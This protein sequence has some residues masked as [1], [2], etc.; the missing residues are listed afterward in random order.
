[1]LDLF[2]CFCLYFILGL[3]FFLFCWGLVSERL[4]RRCGWH[5]CIGAYALLFCGMDGPGWLVTQT[6]TWLRYCRIAMVLCGV[7]EDLTQS[8]S[9]DMKSYFYF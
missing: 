8:I 4:A 2:D 7:A 6:V 9:N 5:V 3:F 1:V